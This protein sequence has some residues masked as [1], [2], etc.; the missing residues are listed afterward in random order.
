MS[1]PVRRCGDRE[2]GVGGASGQVEIP[3]HLGAQ[4]RIYNWAS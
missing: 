3:S 4:T 2:A 1:L